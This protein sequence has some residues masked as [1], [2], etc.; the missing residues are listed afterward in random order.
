MRRFTF[1]SIIFLEKWNI[2]NTVALNGSGV[3]SSQVKMK[4]VSKSKG[5]K[6]KMEGQRAVEAAVSEKL[7]AY[8]NGIA[9][10]DVPQNLL[11]LLDQLDATQ[12]DK[13]SGNS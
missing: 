9:Q 3:A 1:G 12:S 6:I 8:Y 4:I 2:S 7:R 10:Q 11:D 13:K 5:P